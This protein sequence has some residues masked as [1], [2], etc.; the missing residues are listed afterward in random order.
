MD[1]A[2]D[3]RMIAIVGWGQCPRYSPVFAQYSGPC[4]QMAGFVVDSNANVADPTTA[5][6][7]TA[8]GPVPWPQHDSFLSLLPQHILCL[9]FI[10]SIYLSR[11]YLI[12]LKT[13]FT[14]TRIWSFVTSYS[15]HR[16]PCLSLSFTVREKA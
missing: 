7:S 8:S 9:P 10:N 5:A 6:P 4:M 3:S 15:H 16:L 12:D 11:A 1:A 14:T 2:S 13:P